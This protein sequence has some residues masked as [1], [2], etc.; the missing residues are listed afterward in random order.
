[1]HKRFSLESEV[2]NVLNRSGVSRL[3]VGVSGGADSMALVLALKSIGADISCVHCNFHLRGEESMRDENF[4]RAFCRENDI[5][6]EVLNFDVD[7]YIATK[8]S[9]T[10][11]EMAC[12]ELRYNEFFRL[13]K[14]K[15]FDR[16]A[17]AHNSDDNVETLLL[18]L[19]RG[20]GVT[21]LRG[22][23]PDTGTII[24]PLLNVSR[25]E[26]ENYLQE[27]N[28]GFV[29]DHTNLQ[30][31]YRRNF[32]RL[33]ILPLVESRWPGVRKAIGK[34]IENL[35]NEERVLDWCED[36]CLGKHNDFLP[37][38]AISEAPDSLWII[39]RFVS[40]RG[41][42]R[43]IAKEINDVYQKKAGS[44]LIVGKRW[45]SDRG[46]LVFR[47]K[48]LEFIKKDEKHEL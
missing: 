30:S 34:T 20:A 14:A 44:Q 8:G 33:E 10:S 7:E 5:N 6:L 43:D 47:M 3:L 18:N 35:R 12:R 29:T 17:V 46:E 27:N 26:I 13:L 48:G 39:Y 21:G 19:F 25:A 9:G 1:M 41:F 2:K 15:R 40:N 22:M 23:L 16:V 31:D 24:R 32:I 4:V 28:V 37:L 45:N 38:T 42:S 11:V 36:K